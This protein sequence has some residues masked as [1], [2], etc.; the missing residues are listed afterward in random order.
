MFEDI[1]IYVCLLDIAVN[2]CLL[3]TT[4]KT[5]CWHKGQFPGSIIRTIDIFRFLA[6]TLPV[7]FKDM[8]PI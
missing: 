1:D 7:K 2:V 6:K 5:V 8:G 3:Y 4:A